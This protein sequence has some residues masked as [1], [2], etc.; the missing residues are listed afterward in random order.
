MFVMADIII[1]ILRIPVSL[2]DIQIVKTV[3]V[4]KIVFNVILVIFSLTI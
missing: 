4:I 2:V 1:K 3:P